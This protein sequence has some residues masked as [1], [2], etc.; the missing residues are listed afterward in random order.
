MLSA[1]VVFL[2]LSV[3]SFAAP[4]K[5]V[6][7]SLQ[8]PSGQWKIARLKNLP[9]QASIRVDI[10]GNPPLSVLLV[11]QDAYRAYPDLPLPPLFRGKIIN[12]LSFTIKIPKTDHYFLILDN[13]NGKEKSNL[14]IKIQASVG[15]S[16]TAAS[17]SQPEAVQQE[18]NFE[19]KFDLFSVELK[20]IFIFESFPIKS[21]MCTQDGVFS[22]P[23]GIIFCTNFIKQVY[24]SIGNK[25]KSSDIIVFAL[26]HELAHQLLKQ[27]DYPFYDNEEIA[28]EFATIMLI[29][30]DQK[31][32]LSSTAEFFLSTPSSSELVAKIFQDDRH[33][34]S[35]QRS[36]N[37]LRCLKNPEKVRRW[38]HFFIP[39]MQTSMLRKLQN[40]QSS[41]FDLDLVKQE[42]KRRN[43]EK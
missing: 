2:F 43:N 3:P 24:E 31:E 18:S 23:D 37:I 26:F 10:T 4:T 29:V 33:P 5:E 16:T 35:V 1:A 6:E 28:D 13:R 15:S 8:V 19:K 7:L 22:G 40:S 42:L 30:L 9:R 20:K 27:W 41:N 32:R 36:R 14:Q 25:E 11:D 17:V 12:S 39:H 34:L 38:L 21:E